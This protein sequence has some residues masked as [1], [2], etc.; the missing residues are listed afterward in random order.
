V[1]SDRAR[2]ATWRP[3]GL[4]WAGTQP[5]P[6][7]VGPSP[8]PVPS[9]R[10]LQPTDDGPLWTP[11]RTATPAILETIAAPARQRK[12][13]RRR[14]GPRTVAGNNL[15]PAA[16]APAPHPGRADHRPAQAGHPDTRRRRG[17]RPV[18]RCRAHR[19]RR[20]RPAWVTSRTTARAVPP[21]LAGSCAAVVSTASWSAP[22]WRRSTRTPRRPPPGPDPTGSC[23]ACPLARPTPASSAAW[24]ACWPDRGTARVGDHRGQGSALRA[25]D[26]TLTSRSGRHACL[27]GETDDPIR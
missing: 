4:F 9:P 19:R 26:V 23:A 15:P 8:R 6:A 21:G 10:A 16:R 13:Q 18:R 22:P 11:R 24:S 20:V 1:T 14:T 2:P 27:V 25:G 12:R 5:H 3:Y 17:P 7:P